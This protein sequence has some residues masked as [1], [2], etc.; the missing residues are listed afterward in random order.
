MSG[1]T[2]QKLKILKDLIESGKIQVFRDI[3]LYIARTEIASSLGINYTRFLD[4]IKDPKRMRYSE[5]CSLGKILDVAPR[6]ISELIHNQ[7]EASK[8]GKA[9][10]KQSA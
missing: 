9:R 8:P 2:N 7:I 5:T 6:K 10:V 3:F 4:L 1:D